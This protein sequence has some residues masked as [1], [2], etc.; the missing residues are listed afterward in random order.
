MRRRK[1]KFIDRSPHHSRQTQ[2]TVF[3]GLHYVHSPP[4][5]QP[6]WLA[7]SCK[8]LV[9]LLLLLLLLLP[10]RTILQQLQLCIST[11]MLSHAQH[12]KIHKGDRSFNLTLV[13]QRTSAGWSASV[14]QRCF[15]DAFQPHFLW[16]GSHSQQLVAA[17]LLSCLQDV[18][19]LKKFK[20]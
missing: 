6:C 8:S 2:A 7:K 13:C 20:Q 9:L 19:K 15:Q 11:T 1:T 16:P 10:S 17:C 14:P 4:C 5:D 12:V 3:V 18:A